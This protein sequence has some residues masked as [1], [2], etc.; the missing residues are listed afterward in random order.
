VV[1]AMNTNTMLKVNLISI[2]IVRFM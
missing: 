2:E 1:R